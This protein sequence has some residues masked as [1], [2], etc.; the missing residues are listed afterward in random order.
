MRRFLA[1]VITAL[2]H[3]NRKWHNALLRRH[4]SH[5][6]ENP[7]NCDALSDA[8]RLLQDYIATMLIKWFVANIL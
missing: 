2:F 5:I 1:T 7:L 8:L 3:G 4:Q 6:Q